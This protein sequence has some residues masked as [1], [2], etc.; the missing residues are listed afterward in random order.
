MLVGIHGRKE[1]GKTTFANFFD[2]YI[3]KNEQYIVYRRSFATAVKTMCAILLGESYDVDIEDKNKFTNI[4]WSDLSPK[5]QNDYPGFNEFLTYREL[6]QI[7]G[8]DVVREGFMQNAWA[9]IPFFELDFLGE[10]EIIVIDDVRFLNEA[11]LCQEND[12]ILIK[13]LGGNMDDNHKS[14]N[15]GIPDSMFNF[16]IRPERGLERYKQQ[17]FTFLDSNKEKIFS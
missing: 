1:S 8:T 9:R 15:Q 5:I 11:E 12:G 7:F 13:V 16:V 10:N 17:V 2:D 3:S 14:E 4:R 6:W